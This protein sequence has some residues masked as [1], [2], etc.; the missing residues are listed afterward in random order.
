MFIV[1]DSPISQISKKQKSIATSIMDAKYMAM[2]V[3]AKQL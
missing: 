1:I 3:A 2:Y